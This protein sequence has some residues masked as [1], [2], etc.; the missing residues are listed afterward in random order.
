MDPYNTKTYITKE[1]FV[2]ITGNKQTYEGFVIGVGYA[3]VNYCYWHNGVLV[4]QIDGKQKNPAISHLF[5]VKVQMLDLSPKALNLSYGDRE[6]LW[7]REKATGKYIF[8]KKGEVPDGYENMGQYF[9]IK[10]DRGRIR[11]YNIN[12]SVSYANYDIIEYTDGIL[13][14]SWITIAKKEIGVKELPREK[15]NSR[16]IE[17]H[18]ATSGMFNSDEVPWCSSFVN[19]TMNECNIEKT[20]DATAL[21]WKKWGQNLGKVPAY[22][23]IA[24]INY[25]NGRGHVGFVV[26]RN[27][28]GYIIILGGNQS[29]QVKLSAYS[30]KKIE[31]FVYPNGYIPSYEDLPILDN[32]DILNFQSTR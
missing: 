7:I 3:F 8:I 12:G 27:K 21:S 28:K 2:F 9:T 11:S 1:E 19:W 5:I 6:G 25:G 30:E 15:H 17:Y 18:H 31:Q 24:I 20:N 13:D 22:G 29:D 10:D 14:T 16:I 4:C 23:S 32:E 26:G